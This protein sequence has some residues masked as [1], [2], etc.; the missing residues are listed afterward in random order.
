MRKLQ[1]ILALLLLALAF[2]LPV[3]AQGPPRDYHNRLGRIMAFTSGDGVSHPQSFWVLNFAAFA[4][5]D[6]TA[7]LEFV[8]YHSKEAYDAGASPIAGAVRS[9]QVPPEAWLSTVFV[10]VPAPSESFAVNFLTAAWG[11]A[12]AAKEVGEAPAEGQPDTRV[13]FFAGSVAVQ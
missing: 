6:S 3:R 11:V 12:L 8:G 13:S 2:T 7:R 1:H 10:P 9:Y 4:V 5:G